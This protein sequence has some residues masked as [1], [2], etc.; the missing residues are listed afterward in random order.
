MYIKTGTNDSLLCSV[1]KT[2][3]KLPQKL[4]SRLLPWK[5]RCGPGVKITKDSWVMEMKLIGKCIEI[6]TLEILFVIL[7][8]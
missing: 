4:Q 5:Q 3:F 7:I 2:S 6:C 8:K 1:I